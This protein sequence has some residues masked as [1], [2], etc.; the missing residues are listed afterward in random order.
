[1]VSRRAHRP[2]DQGSNPVFM[3][4]TN[5]RSEGALISRFPERGLN[6][7]NFASTVQPFTIS[8]RTWLVPW[9]PVW[10]QVDT[11]SGDRLTVTSQ[12]TRGSTSWSIAHCGLARQDAIIAT[13]LAVFDFSHTAPVNTS[14]QLCYSVKTLASSSKSWLKQWTEV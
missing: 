4:T 14:R 9:C 3:C 11:M 2:H 10:K 8:S 5:F 13:T 1:M 6:S 12:V 7:P